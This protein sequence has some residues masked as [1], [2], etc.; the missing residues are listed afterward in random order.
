MRLLRALF[1]ILFPPRATEALVRAASLGDLGRHARAGTTRDGRIFLLPYAVP[2]VRGAI[3][4]AKFRGSEHAETLLAGVLAEYLRDWHADQAAY[5]PRA[6]V[7]VPIPLSHERRAVR[8]YN[9]AERIAARALSQVPEIRLELL[10][11]RTRDTV[12]QTSLGRRARLRNLEGAFAA[13][14]PISPT[15]TY[16]VFDDVSTTGATLGAACATLTGAGARDCIALS[17]AH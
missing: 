17:L 13:T 10:L 4:E 9:Q 12:P 6:A 16:I 8:G 3:L 11:A 14:G 5:E 7:L 1:D 15:P 2:L